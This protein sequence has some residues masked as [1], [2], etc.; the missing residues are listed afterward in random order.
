MNKRMSLVVFSGTADKLTA[1][2]TLAT[3]A[4]AMGMDVELFLTFWGLEAFRKGAK[5]QPPRIAAEFADYGPVMMELMQAKNVPHWLDT[6]HDAREIGNLKVFAGQVD[7]PFFVDLG[8]VFDLLSLRPQRP[9]VGYQRP[10]KGVDGLAGFNVH[11]IAIQVPIARLVTGDQPVL[12]V[13]ATTSR[14]ATRVL[15]PLGGVADSGSWVQV[16]RLGLPLVNEAVLPL[17]L[18]D[19]FNGLTPDADYGLFTSYTPA[20]QLL[21]KSVLTP[22]LQSLLKGL[23]NVPAPGG[24]RNDLVSIFLTG[25]KTTKEFTIHTK[26]GAVNLPP[27]TVVNMPTSVQ[28]AE[29]LRINTA[30]ACTSCSVASL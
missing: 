1:V 9:P 25:M 10:S 26:S 7:D 27:G 14:R 3:G 18:K 17:A 15:A 8:S 30:P 6:L 2:A 20:G 5:T 23:Y 22:E 28:P 12:G 19:A 21:A 4:A 16:S 13:W 11:A 29:M 24:P